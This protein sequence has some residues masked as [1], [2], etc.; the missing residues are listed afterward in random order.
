MAKLSLRSRDCARCDFFIH[1]T[2]IIKICFVFSL[3]HA[4]TLVGCDSGYCKPEHFFF[5]SA[6][7]FS[8]ALVDFG[9]FLMRQLWFHYLGK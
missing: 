3:A 1:L 7:C 5:A 6:M 9:I 8:E 4:S 2:D